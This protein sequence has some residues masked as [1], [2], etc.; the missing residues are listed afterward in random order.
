MRENQGGTFDYY[1]Q[2]FETTLCHIWL[3]LG[4]RNGR[5]SPF[6]YYIFLQPENVTEKLRFGKFENSVQSKIVKFHMNLL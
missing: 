4:V 6:I 2:Y 5:R 3:I 1:S